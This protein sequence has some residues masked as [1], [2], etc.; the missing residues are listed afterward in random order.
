[1]QVRVVQHMMGLEVQPMQVLVVLNTLV[2][3]D[4]SMPVQ[5]AELM[6]ALVVQDILVPVGQPMTAQVDQLMPVQEDP[7]M[8]AQA[9]HAIQVQEVW[10]GIVLVFAN[11]KIYVVP[12]LLY[13]LSNKDI[14]G[15]I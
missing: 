8:M 7:V 1:M 11:R 3:E 15:K 10:Q 6:Q 5:E 12:Y 14:E 13:N 2:Q 4:L 9:A